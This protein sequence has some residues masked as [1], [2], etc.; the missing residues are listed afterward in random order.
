MR[1]PVYK[2][3][4]QSR[5]SI[6]ASRRKGY[7]LKYKIDT[8]VAARPETHGIFC[9]KREKDAVNFCMSRIGMILKV[10]PIG[11]GKTP[12]S[13]CNLS[14][15]FGIPLSQYYSSGTKYHIWNTPTGTICYPAV[16]VLE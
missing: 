13:I 12:T 7:N 8:I 14:L 11:K 6:V 10:L 2:V 1:R 9:F 3:V 15:S 16:K 5:N 4:T